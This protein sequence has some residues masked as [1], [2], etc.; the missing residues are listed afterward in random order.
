MSRL[1]IL[2]KS[3]PVQESVLRVSSHPVE[4]GHPLE[5][6]PASHG[7]HSPGL[8]AWK[9]YCRPLYQFAGAKA[10]AVLRGSL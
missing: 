10:G 6:V 9:V 7:R 3:N 2:C 4:R 8:E 5:P 1:E